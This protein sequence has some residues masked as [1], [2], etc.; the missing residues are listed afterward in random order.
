MSDPGSHFGVAVEMPRLQ[1]S[2][3]LARFCLLAINVSIAGLWGCHFQFPPILGSP[4]N[5]NETAQSV[6]L[7]PIA[8][9]P[10]STPAMTE[11]PDA[12]L[13]AEQA[14]KAAAKA[15]VAAEKAAAAS[16]AATLASAEATEAAAQAQLAARLP[17]N[18]PSPERRRKASKRFVQSAAMTHTAPSITT[19]IKP[20]TESKVS[21][22]PVTTEGGTAIPSAPAPSITP[23]PNLVSAAD[24]EQ[25]QLT[26]AAAAQLIGK[27][28]SSL[29]MVA[30]D[31][32]SAQNVERYDQASKLLKSARD[33]FAEQDYVAAHSLA[34]KAAILIRLL[35]PAGT[36]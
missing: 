10:A 36:P 30:R 14:V 26:Q 9:T 8:P 23:P 12:S 21:T 1:S 16:K 7:P 17:S 32:L 33:S 29:K 34:D 31:R 28:A 3:S 5:S 35:T 6:P 13:V 18:T 2:F 19:P 4:A 20:A 15:R 22:S 24:A 11:K 27:D 25:V